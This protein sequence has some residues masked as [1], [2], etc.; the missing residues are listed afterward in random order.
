MATQRLTGLCLLDLSA[1]FDTIDHSILLSRLSTWFGIKHSS[2]NW[3][4]TFLCN[5]TYSVQISGVTS[6][7]SKLIYGVPQGSVLGPI[8]FALYTTP[9]SSLISSHSV[10]HHLFADDTQL[11]TCFS[12]TDFSN[13]NQS[14]ATTFQAISRWMSLNFLAL[15]PSKTEFIL[16][17]T[18]QQL[19]KLHNPLLN[20]S[21]DLQIK[22]ATCVRNLGVMF[23]KH[24][25]FHDHI[26]KL[27]QTC[28]FHIKDLRRLRPYLSLE[29]ASTIGA[30]LV[31]SKLDYCNSLFIN[32]PSTEI[33]RLQLIQ[34][35]L[36]RAVY[37]KSKFCHIT[38]VLK[39]L[40]WLKI[41][42]RIQYK[43]LSMTSKILNTS[44]PEYLSDLLNLQSLGSTRSSKLL[45]LK[46]PPVISRLSLTN[47]AFQYAA[48][49]LWNSLP[50]SLRTPNLQSP[51]KLDFT[52]DQFH[53]NLKTHLFRLS[54][55]E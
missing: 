20:L 6:A 42:E 5:R 34:N 44:K 7:P 21:S 53:K 12:P 29:T 32:L 39:S 2:L 3:I 55:P 45:T 13:S 48:P 27:S 16:F 41:R 4:S 19:S 10:N 49:Q 9:L 17:G 11:Y 23:D 40:H 25:S 35:S 14:I 1:A 51:T 54:Y 52:S 36:A 47:R 15:N 31:H 37:R 22:P 46:R 50:P 30:S 8:L 24:L 26:T 38:P 43:I 33:H 18:E 28:F